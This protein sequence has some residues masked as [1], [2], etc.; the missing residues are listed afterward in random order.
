MVYKSEKVVIVNEAEYVH[1][2]LRI[3]SGDQEGHREAGELNAFVILRLLW[4][5]FCLMCIKLRKFEK[6]ICVDK[7]FEMCYP[8][9]RYMLHTFKELLL[10]QLR[11]NTVII[12]SHDD[13]MFESCSQIIKLG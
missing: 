7:L 3:L 9:T 8:C 2:A 10:N 13:S 6:K 11:N 12:I 5:Q 1:N 4:L